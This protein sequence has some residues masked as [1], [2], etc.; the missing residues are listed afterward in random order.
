MDISE[1]FSKEDVKKYSGEQNLQKLH[2]AVN[3]KFK[4]PNDILQSEDPVDKLNFFTSNN[5]ILTFSVVRHP[6]TRYN[7]RIVTYQVQK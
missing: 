7:D 3:S 2:I 6:Y 5:S 4:L 1:Q